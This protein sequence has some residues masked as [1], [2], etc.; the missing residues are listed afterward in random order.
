MVIYCLFC[1]PGKGEY[2]R[3]A[4]TALF[5][6][7]AIYPK[8][9]QHRRKDA[10][11]SPNK[12]NGEYEEY[13][14]VERDLLPGY[15]F[16]YFE[17]DPPTIWRLNRMDDVIRCL[18]NSAGNFELTDNDEEFALMLLEKNGIIG[19]TM[20][21]QEGDHLTICKGAFKNV[22]ATIL[23]VDRRN[24]LMQVEILFARQ[25]VKTWLE[26]EIVDSNEME[27]GSNI[28][29]PQKDD[30]TRSSG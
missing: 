28:T 15:V 27:K 8:Q 23:K 4:A 14:N 11:K 9:I 22:P 24:N 12:R 3:R 16:L 2:V 10:E 7:R 20:V 26:Y 5:D 30:S 19:K 17:K 13:R 18:S 1:E 25:P 6:C 29:G 21:Y